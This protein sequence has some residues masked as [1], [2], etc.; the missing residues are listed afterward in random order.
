MIHFEIR[1]QMPRRV[2]ISGSKILSDLQPPIDPDIIDPRRIGGRKD[3]K[4]NSPRRK[5][6]HKDQRSF[7]IFYISRLME[8]G[9]CLLEHVLSKR[10][11]LFVRQSFESFIHYP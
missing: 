4:K 5:R 8:Y 6:S 1:E 10:V 9:H 7:L 2:T 11:K 3:Q